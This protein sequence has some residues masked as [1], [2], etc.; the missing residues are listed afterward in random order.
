M[1]FVSVPPLTATVHSHAARTPAPRNY[2]FYISYTRDR[3]RLLQGLRADIN[4]LDLSRL[5]AS[6]PTMVY[7]LPA[8]MPRLI[9]SVEG[10]IGTWVKG[11]V[12]QQSGIDTGARPGTL[13]R[14]RVRN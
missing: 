10:Y 11:D 1:P 3:G 9:D 12:V 2:T 5:R 13:L 8:G 6:A 7:D 4:L 14:S